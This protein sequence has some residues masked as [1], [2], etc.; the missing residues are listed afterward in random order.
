MLECP[1]SPS[2]VLVPRLRDTRVCL[3]ELYDEWE[4][5]YVI[6]YH[7]KGVPLGHDLLS[8]QEVAWPVLH[9]THHQGGSVTVAGK[10]KL[11]ATGTHV[12]DTPKNFC[13]VIHIACVLHIN[14][15]DPP[16]FFLGVLFPQQS[17]SVYPALYPCLHAAC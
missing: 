7:G 1:P 16:V 14:E 9:V 6:C 4:D 3:P 15:E 10:I 17:H 12:P 11:R 13:P 5:H 8:M 2:V